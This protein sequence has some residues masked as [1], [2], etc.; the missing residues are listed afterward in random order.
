[1]EEQVREMRPCCWRLTGELGDS[2]HHKCELLRQPSDGCRLDT[3]S[4][5]PSASL[6]RC[7]APCMRCTSWLLLPLRIATRFL[8]LRPRT[9]AAARMAA[10]APEGDGEPVTF[11]SPACPGL[12]FGVQGQPGVILL[13]EWLGV[14]EQARSVNA[15]SA[16]RSRL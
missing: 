7:V 9:H 14:N 5:D 6:S 16:S 13:Q 10:L 2:C 8:S 1:M 15:S 4:F 11:R 12:L 3:H